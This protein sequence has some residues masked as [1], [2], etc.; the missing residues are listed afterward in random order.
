ME[1]DLLKHWGCF[2]GRAIRKGDVK[3]M[4]KIFKLVFFFLKCVSWH[5][6]WMVGF[7]PEQS[8]PMVRLDGN[9]I[10]EATSPGREV[11]TQFCCKPCGG[12]RFS[13]GYFISLYSGRGSWHRR[14]AELFQ[15]VQ[16]A[17]PQYA[18][19]NCF[20]KHMHQMYLFALK[21]WEP[22]TLLRKFSFHID[23]KSLTV[24]SNVPCCTRQWA[25]NLPWPMKLFRF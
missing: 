19:S 7:F 20:V 11:N 22:Q 4:F 16:T 15:A 1:C 6:C 8:N 9:P 12:R 2:Q 14:F 24:L 21:L 10:Q 18:A 25:A 5:N 17:Q 3:A 23:I 13:A